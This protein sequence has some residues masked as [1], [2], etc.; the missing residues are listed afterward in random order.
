MTAYCLLPTASSAQS[1]IIVETTGQPDKTPKPKPKPKPVPPPKPAEPEF[2]AP[3]L[4]WKTLVKPVEGGILYGGDA[5][6]LGGGTTLH[7]LD[8]DGRPQWTA[9]VGEQ[10]AVAALDDRRVFFGGEKGTLYAFTQRSGS[11]L[12]Q[13]ASE[14][15]AA[16]QNAPAVGGGKIFVECLDNNLYALNAANGQLLW[17]FTRPDGSLGYSAPVFDSGAIY[18]AGETTLYKLDAATGNVLWKIF[19]GGKSLSTP[20]LTDKAV[21]IGGDGPGVCAFARDSGKPLWNFPGKIENDWF[22]APLIA[23]NRVYVGTYKGILYA[24]DAAGTPRWASK[25]P[26]PSLT[27]PA[28]DAK[29]GVLYLT[30]LTYRNEPCALGLAASTGRRLWDYGLDTVT[31]PPTLRADRLYIGS[32][33][34]YLY[35]FGLK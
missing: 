18:I 21:I 9:E 14:T 35:A 2:V 20:A 17:K 24:L 4:L 29:R 12:W 6:F 10:R 3:K 8:E 16:I 19:V 26:G 25:L 1:P 23:G 22:G 5:L 31:S 13:F 34:G 11:P 28:L 15:G 32:T 33:N 27:R 30:C 7:K